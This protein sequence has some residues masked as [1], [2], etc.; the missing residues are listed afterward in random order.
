MKTTQYSAC[1]MRDTPGR[2][3]SDTSSRSGDETELT[4]STLVC[5]DGPYQDALA[6]GMADVAEDSEWVQKH[7]L[8]CEQTMVMKALT[9]SLLVNHCLQTCLPIVSVL[10]RAC[11]AADGVNPGPG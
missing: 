10:V 5:V 9:R 7:V 1:V 6:Y 2:Q 3:W 11:Y 4:L 8:D